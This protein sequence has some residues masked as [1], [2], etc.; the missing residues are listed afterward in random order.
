MK[1]AVLHGFRTP[2]VIEDQPIPSPGPGEILIH[3]EACGVCHS[4]LHVCDADW[5]SLRKHTKLPLVPGHE[6][7]GVVTAVG[8]A[9]SN[10]SVGDRAG[11]PWLYWTC[12]DCEYC[13]AGREPLCGRQRITGVMES[14]GFAEFL[15]A[16][17]SH[18]VRIPPA[19]SSTEAAPLFCAGL[20]V[21]RA[22]RR[23]E[24]EAGQTVAVYGVGGLGHL[25]VQI[26]R[27]RGA[28]VCAV[29]VAEEKL[30]LARECGAHTTVHLPSGKPP[31]AHVAIVC[32]ASAAAYESA[33]RGLRK[34]GTLA[35]VGMPAE[36]VPVPMF[37]M[38][39]GEIRMVASAVGTR[40]ELRE[41]LDL[42]AAG[43]IR[44]RIETHKLDEINTVFDRLRH[45][46]VPARAVVVP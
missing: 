25:A 33:L 20:T 27:A 31:R 4:D 40:A 43:A 32:S 19:L 15:I 16:K 5:E 10:W 37:S 45:G 24:I 12:G 6:A 2:L 39:S 17:A 35:V 9:V 13:A 34:G 1:A 46:T 36:P 26:A 14:G 29:D 21:Y 22:L 8:E 44:C 18:A 41:V 30:E 38:V 42:A 28:E 7:A 3:V 11:V 23:A